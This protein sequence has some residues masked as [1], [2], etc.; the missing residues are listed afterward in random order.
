MVT[1]NKLLHSRALTACP[2]IFSAENRDYIYGGGGGGGISE[3]SA[4]KHKGKT[5]HSE[6]TFTSK[7]A[8]R[9][10]LFSRLCSHVTSR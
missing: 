4:A 7:I 8:S 6:R 3:Y 10:L 1:D 2:V 5:F 9:Y